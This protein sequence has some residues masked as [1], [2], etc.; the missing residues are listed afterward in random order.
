MIVQLH[1][2]I[3][4]SLSF[5]EAHD[6]SALVQKTI[7]ANLAE[8]IATIHA[9]PYDASEKKVRDLCRHDTLKLEGN[10]VS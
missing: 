2:E 9:D 5:V 10:D 3:D 7:E 4:S 1:L 6:I 8:C